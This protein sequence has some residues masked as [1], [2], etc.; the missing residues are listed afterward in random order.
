MTSEATLTLCCV[1]YQLNSVAVF[2][3][4]GKPGAYVDDVI[5]VRN[6]SIFMTQDCDIGL[7]CQRTA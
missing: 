6:S 7:D 4:L 1:M 5:N 3:Y 2:L